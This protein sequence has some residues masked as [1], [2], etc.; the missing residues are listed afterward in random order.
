MTFSRR[1]K[2]VETIN[3]FF[4]AKKEKIVS[5]VTK[6]SPREYKVYNTDKGNNY[7]Y[8]NYRDTSNMCCI[9]KIN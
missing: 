3:S 4:K 8:M 6:F 1:I 9:A 5:I 7:I 2:D